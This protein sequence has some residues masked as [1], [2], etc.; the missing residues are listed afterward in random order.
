MKRSNWV[1]LLL[2]AVA[3]GAY[4]LINY[5]KDKT[6]AEVTP[7]VVGTSFLFQET[8]TVLQSIRIYDQDYH[9]VEL[10]RG[11]G[12]LWTVSLPTPGAADQSLA[13]AAET[14]LG[15]LQVV[16]ELG[17]VPSLSDFGLTFPAYTIKLG[18]ANGVEHKIELGNLTPTSS[19]YYVQL[20]D[21]Q[22]Y[23]VSQYSLDAVLTLIDNPPY[24]PTSTP[25]PA[26]VT[27]EEVTPTP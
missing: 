8:D 25:E 18:F 13:G 12:N 1:L 2:L 7:T 20:D 3:I 27:P 15:A 4:F 9:I 24:L 19:G 14:Q 22:V 6:A 5:R 10:T 17:T 16:T 21:G 26:T 23:V 11:Q